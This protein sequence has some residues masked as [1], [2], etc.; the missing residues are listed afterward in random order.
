V[1]NGNVYHTSATKMIGS[2]AD[3]GSFNNSEGNQ[4]LTAAEAT[5]ANTVMSGQIA[6]AP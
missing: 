6:Q 4:N 1:W 5:F 2:I 3:F